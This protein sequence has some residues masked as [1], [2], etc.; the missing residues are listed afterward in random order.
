[1]FYVNSATAPDYAF[2]LAGRM[3]SVISSGYRL[4]MCYGILCY[5]GFSVIF[6]LAQALSVGL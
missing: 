2:R 5:C 4:I 3:D 6:R 1:M